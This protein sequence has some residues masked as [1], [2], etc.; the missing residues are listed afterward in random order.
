MVEEIRNH[1][2]EP[3]DEELRW[4]NVE[5][6]SIVVGLMVLAALALAIGVSATSVADAPQPVKSVAAGK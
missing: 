2:A 1:D 4:M 5:P 3:T 6:V